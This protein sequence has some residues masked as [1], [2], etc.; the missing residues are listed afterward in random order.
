MTKRY[1]ALALVL[2][3]WALQASGQPIHGHWQCQ[4]YVADSVT[5]G[6][7]QC[8]LPLK[9]SAQCHWI[10]P[11]LSALSEM[12][13]HTHIEYPRPNFWAVVNSAFTQAVDFVLYHVSGFI[14]ASRIEGDYIRR[15]IWDDTG[16]TTPPPLVG[17]PNSVVTYHAHIT[18]DPELGAPAKGWWNPRLVAITRFA[19]STSTKD[20]FFYPLYS[21]RDPNA[22][23]SDNRPFLSARCTGFPVNV[24]G[25]NTSEFRGEV[26]PPIL[27]PITSP[28]TGTVLPYGYGAQEV[29]PLGMF[30][31]LSDLNL[32]AGIP[33][34]LL[35]SEQSFGG[36][37]NG[38][39][40]TF[41]PAIGP[42]VH[43]MAF[44]WDQPH[45]TAAG[46]EEATSLLV[47]Q[48]TVADGGSTPPPPVE[49]CGNAIDDDGDGL[50][51]EGCVPPPVD[52]QI[53]TGVLQRLN[54]Q[55]RVCDVSDGKC[56]ILGTVN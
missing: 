35:A 47:M 56:L 30:Q 17:D 10:T 32:H 20:E 45:P 51:D 41:S 3:G 26:Y 50:I 22:P 38:N 34:T 39:E 1:L 7:G 49:V 42:G 6:P 11:A 19:D 23:E 36:N 31:Q 48:Y 12:P 21:T 44:T 43:T 15:I 54:D 28:W 18:Y 46:L 37:P 40:I 5:P 13:S 2:L 52:W 55:I 24:W 16:T 33:G 4:E 27:G 14:D 25:T 53:V 29:L 8:H 9:Q